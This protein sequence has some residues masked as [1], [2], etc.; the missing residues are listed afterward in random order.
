M[1][2]CSIMSMY[3]A[4]TFLCMSCTFYFAQGKKNNRKV[5]LQVLTFQVATALLSIQSLF[6]QNCELSVSNHSGKY[7]SLTLKLLHAPLSS[8]ET[9]ISLGTLWLKQVVLKSSF[10]LFKKYLSFHTFSVS[11]LNLIV[12]R[13][14]SG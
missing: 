8:Y 10:S 4:H 14:A 11:A 5:W 1:F 7:S 6:T 9:I 13:V 3:S 2:V 12:E